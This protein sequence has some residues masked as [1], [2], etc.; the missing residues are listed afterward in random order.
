[1]VLSDKTK[2]RRGGRFCTSP[3]D[4]TLSI[5]LQ[6][7]W[8]GVPGSSR[9]GPWTGNQELRTVG[10][11]S[12]TH[13]LLIALLRHSWRWMILLGPRFVDQRQGLLCL[14]AKV[15]PYDLGTG[16]PNFKAPRLGPRAFSISL[17]NLFW[18]NFIWMPSLLTH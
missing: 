18:G 6:E 1:M 3:Y 15:E 11:G 2:L 4:K 8:P 7:T 13:V 5:P 12:R 10:I 16:T 9:L 17:V 14:I